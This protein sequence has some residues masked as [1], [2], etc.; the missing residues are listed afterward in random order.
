MPEN[1]GYDVE[2]ESSDDEE[3]EKGLL[4]LDVNKV[5]IGNIPKDFIGFMLSR[6]GK[7][8]DFCISIG[9]GDYCVISIRS[10]NQHPC[11]MIVEKY[12]DAYRARGLYNVSGRT[13]GELLFNILKSP[14]HR[15]NLSMNDGYAEVILKN[16]RRM[17]E[18][19]WKQH[20]FDE[21]KATFPAED[22]KLPV[23]LMLGVIT[24][25]GGGYMVYSGAP[26]RYLQHFL[27]ENVHSMS[28]WTKI[29]V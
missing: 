20:I 17:D 23:R 6:G 4:T 1:V 25:R 7:A 14:Y 15:A 10:E 12:R 3:F 8:G 5:K 13:I 16:N 29:K 9:S 28:C 27:Q 2:V 22:L 26:G 24:W 11:H 18:Q 21:L 19:Q